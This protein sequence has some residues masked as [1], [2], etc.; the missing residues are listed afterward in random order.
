M[1][2]FL[3][4]KELYLKIISYFIKVVD[5]EADRRMNAKCPGIS[6]FIATSF[7]DLVSTISLL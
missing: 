7:Q 4:I 3:N 1:T 6:P 5:S 2:M